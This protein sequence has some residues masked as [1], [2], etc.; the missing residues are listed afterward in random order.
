MRTIPQRLSGGAGLTYVAHCGTSDEAPY[1]A[2]AAFLDEKD[3][4]RPYRTDAVHTSRLGAYLALMRRILETVSAEATKSYV[5]FYPA[6]PAIA[7]RLREAVTERAEDLGEPGTESDW[8]YLRDAW[9]A[10][11]CGVSVLIQKNGPGT[12]TLA[13]LRALD[14]EADSVAASE[15]DDNLPLPEPD[16]DPAPSPARGAS[17]EDLFG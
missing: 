14:G 1:R 15:S 11:R 13:V 12:G 3:R 17:H 9:C 7:Q 10:E 4:W 5:F 6:D 2:A 8:H 16:E